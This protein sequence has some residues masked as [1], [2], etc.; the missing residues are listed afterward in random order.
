[1]E[2][3]EKQEK[4]VYAHMLSHEEINA[5]PGREMK[6]KRTQTSKL[7]DLGGGHYQAVLYP[8][9]V[10]IKNA[11]G[12][13]EEIDHTLTRKEKVLMNES[14]DLSVQFAPGGG[15]ALSRGTHTLSWILPDA[16]PV[17]AEEEIPTEKKLPLF[18]RHPEDR[19]LESTVQYPELFPGVDMTAQILPGRF[20]DTLVFKNDQ[21]VRPVEFH[22][23]APD[24]RLI[25]Q[26]NGD[27]LAMDEEQII[28]RLPAPFAMDEQGNPVRGS[29]HVALKEL[30][31]GYWAW[32]VELDK[33]FAANAAF[34]VCL[35]PV[36][37]TEQTTDAVSMAYVTSKNPSTNY[38]ATGYSSNIAHNNYNWGECYTFLRFDSLPVID[39][40][41]YVTAATLTMKS[42]ADNGGKHVYLREVLD[43]WSST[44]ITYTKATNGEVNV[45][46]K[47]LEYAN[48]GSTGTAV[49]FNIA[50]QVRQ[51]YA[52]TNHGLRLEMIDEGLV[53]L[54]AMGA[55]YYKPYVTIDYIS[56]A[57]LE[58]YLAQESHNCGRAGTAYVGLFNGNLVVAHQD[59]NMNGSLMPFSVTRYYN[60]C[61]HDVNP[62]GAGYGWKY[63]SQQ[64]LHRETIGS[65]LHY[66]YMDG[67]GTRHHFKQT[68]GTWNDLSGLSLKL[69]ISGSTATIAD[70]GDNT[71]TFD[72]PTAEFNNNYSNVKM[73]KTMAD[74]LG[75]T[76]T[77]THNSSRLTTAI[78]DGANRTTT[79]TAASITAPGMNAV[80]SVLENN[81]L[82]KI[83]HEDGKYVQYAYDAATGLLNKMTNH[84]NSSLEFIYTS[85]APY[86]VTLVTYKDKNGAVCGGRKYEYG[87]CRTAVTDMIPS[88]SA[89][90]AGKTLVYHFND[91]GNV[92]SVNDGLG[93]GCFAGYSSSMPLNHPEYTSKMQRAVNNYLKNHHFLTVN[94]DWTSALLNGASGSGAYNSEQVYA[95][96]RAY[97][98]EKTSTAGQVTVYQNVTLT[99]GKTY[100]FSCYYRTAN[101]AAVQ[102]RVEYKNSSGTTVN[103]DSATA[104]STDRWD[105]IFLPF[106]LP[107]NSTS[108]TVTV[109]MMATEGIGSV[110]VDA[111]Q[112]EDG[113]VANRYNLLQNGAF[114]MNSS[115]VPT[116]WTAGSENVAADDCLVSG[117]NIISGRPSELKGRVLRVKGAAGKTKTFS[118]YFSCIGSS[119]DTY[120][121]GGWSANYSRPRTPASASAPCRYEM[122]IRAK[123]GSSY[124]SVG[125]VQWSEEWS[126]WQ[127]G[128]IPI[129]MPGDYTDV[130]IVITYQN[131]LNEAQF[132]NL[133]LHKEEFGKTF[134][135]DTSGNVTSVKNLAALQSHAT[136]DSFNNMLTYQQPGRPGTAQYTQ[137]WGSTDAEK[138]KHL[139][140]TSKSPLSI[141]QEYSYDSK[142]NPTS[143]KTRNNSSSLVIGSTTAYNDTT[144]PNYVASQTDARGKTV[145]TVTDANKGTV[146]SVTAPNGQTVSYTYDSLKRNTAVSTAVSGSTYKNSYTYTGDLL[147]Q[148][149][150]N[151]DT[152]TA[153]DVSYNFA[154]DAQNR[155]TTVK[156]GT[157]TLSTNTYNT[158][159]G[160]LK[161]GTLTKVTYGNNSSSVPQSVAYTYDDYKRVTKVTID[162]STAKTY[163]F[164]YGANGQVAKLVD[165]ILNR[166]TYSEYDV[167]NRPMRIT[168]TEGSSHVYTGQVWY[169]EYNNLKTFKEWVG[170]GKTQFRT[171]FTYDTEN[172]PTKLTYG[173]D[174]NKVEY[175]YDGI[176]RSSNRSVRFGTSDSNRTYSTDYSYLAGSHNGSTTTSLISGITQTGEIFTYT[177]DNVGNISSVTQNSKTTYYVYDNLGQLI[178]VND[179]NDPTSGTAGTT[180]VYTYDLGGNI[181]TKKRY[182]YTTGTVGTVR[183]S[184]T[185]TYGDSNWRDKLTQYSVQ[186][187]TNP[188]TTYTVT[189]DVIGNP[190]SDG[191]WS[192]TWEKGRQ[193]KQ[194]VKSGTTATFKYNSEGL[195]VQKTVNGTV[196]NYTLHGKN[197]VHMT[198]GS[199]VLHFWYDASNRPAIVQFNG[200]KYA[201][202]H[203][204]QGDIV[205]IL[206]T[207]GTEVVKYTYDAWGKVLSTTG[208]LASTLGTIQPFRY[209]GYVYDVETGVYYLRSRYYTP[210]WGR[211]V[212]ADIVLGS[213]SEI[214]NNNLYSYCKNSP[215]ILSDFDGFVW[216]LGAYAPFYGFYHLQVQLWIVNHNPN[217]VMEKNTSTGRIDLYN[218]ITKEIYE[219]KPWT[220]A[221]I[222]AGIDQLNRYITGDLSVRKGYSMLLL[223]P[224]G[225]L[226]YEY[227]NTTVDIIV[228]Q[229]GPLITYRLN[230][231]RKR[232]QEAYEKVSI[233]EKSTEPS[234]QKEPMSA[235][236]YIGALALIAITIFTPIPG[237]EVV[238]MGVILTMP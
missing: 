107:S 138:K 103:T 13:W 157:Q 110:W 71:M 102:L 163:Q 37:E 164:E 56:L 233:V 64:T 96:G 166:I 187:G 150:H 232:K 23:Y 130:M 46:D 227:P 89:L 97:K 148:V 105:R 174:Y 193:L 189:S 137:T 54:G 144:Y 126:G 206:N 154:F 229:H 220:E 205:G 135:Y 134:A 177:Y 195:R 29:A 99:K 196:T 62:F 201:Y 18:P 74:A 238:A 168:T 186:V 86:R 218:T 223:P 55:T 125:K 162:G 236:A 191:T 124:T 214:I 147:T 202:I 151:T 207:S 61:Y 32:I 181:K 112:V 225:E 68:S 51:W 84:D 76:V 153:N 75:N 6:E 60:S 120:V 204:L 90:T 149:K 116:G 209:R 121:A 22:L 7:Y 169:D 197:I 12:E 81:K 228:R 8:E 66:V 2:S 78:K 43:D 52:G 11:Q 44:T 224:D 1:M 28:F 50:N 111:A 167:E 59:T 145:T 152:A 208:S 73:I 72:L 3:K 57:G 114:T 143:A 237:D 58:G 176:G 63:S 113:P 69:T 132:S 49:N 106:T 25:Q 140:R 109:R 230:V 219:V 45:S 142:G 128:A 216:V 194:M 21:A 65:V 87:D 47:Y 158:T 200:T 139:L 79:L 24:L 185:F 199:N 131:N 104:A 215:V 19:V 85:Q 133:F 4:L 17:E 100:T 91:A 159:A 127:F 30:D 38:P 129:V 93:Y 117:S 92:V 39:S 183:E 33:E 26:E 118:Q 20:K 41:Y 211:F 31:R 40:S 9:P 182:D 95:G 15:I 198:Q 77:F 101:A 188:A 123:I 35:D 170:A 34:P 5:L 156:V 136:Y 179:Q 14:S 178:R 141:W 36:V 108:A 27:V 213:L 146:T 160:S 83:T 203:N 161:Y 171:D 115:G 16:Q 88:G 155:P 226:H 82:T 217:I 184:V 42:T 94:S 180:W 222:S 80:T 210:V 122:E 192:Y 221:H 165:S 172:K 190:T 173:D 48:A 70:K 98:L 231:K 10:H 53:Q 119:G 212:T 67:D 234:T 175:T 235:L